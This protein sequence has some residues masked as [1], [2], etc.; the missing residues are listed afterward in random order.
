MQ[1]CFLNVGYGECQLII[2]AKGDVTI[3]DGGSADSDTYKVKATL[4]LSEA[5][6]LLDIHKIKNLICTHAHYD[7]LAGLSELIAIPSLHIENFYIN[8]L[9]PEDF[10]F[11]D[12][13]SKGALDFEDYRLWKYALRAYRDLIDYLKMQGTHIYEAKEEENLILDE[14]LSLKI[15]GLNSQQKSARLYELKALATA[16]RETFIKALATL[17]RHENNQSLSFILK[18]KEHQCCLTGD[19]QN[20]EDLSPQLPPCTLLKLTHHGQKDGLPE[21]L[22]EKTCPKKFVI[23]ADYYRKYHAAAPEVI[24]KI[25]AFAKASNIESQIFITGDLNLSADTYGS[26]LSFN[27]NLHASFPISCTKKRPSIFKRSLKKIYLGK[28]DHLFAGD[29]NYA[30]KFLYTHIA[31]CDIYKLELQFDKQIV[32]IMSIKNLNN[33]AQP[34]M[35]RLYKNFIEMSI[36]DEESSIL[37]LDFYAENSV[38]VA[39]N[40]YYYL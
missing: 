1:L 23:C 32:G 2:D 19:R 30:Y 10:K 34:L 5:L 7:H 24:S 17:N 22:L 36:F 12:L 3:I 28:N 20:W 4:R 14:N 16:D 29:E 25:K 15:F 35:L 6:E 37:V 40:L 39:Q 11:P 27:E 9:L 13:P 18:T 33:K 21:I 31:P 26:L 8:Q 38:T